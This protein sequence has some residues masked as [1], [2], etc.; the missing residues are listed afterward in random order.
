M[1]NGYYSTRE[2][3]ILTGRPERKVREWCRNGK[4]KAIK[5]GGGRDWYV[6]KTDLAEFYP[7]V[8][9]MSDPTVGIE[10]ET[11]A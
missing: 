11:T 2:I 5:P 3:A 1:Q 7:L 9:W 4:V 8:D 10:G 6:H